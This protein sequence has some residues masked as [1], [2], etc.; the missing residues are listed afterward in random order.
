[1]SAPATASPPGAAPPTRTKIG[2]WTL[3]AERNELARDGQSVRL[4]PKVIEVLA[5]LAQRP[6]RVVPREELLSAVW[7]GVVVGD[8]TLT[9]AIIKLRKALGDDAHRPRYIETISK[10]GYRLIAPVEESSPETAGGTKTRM[11]RRGAG[12]VILGLALVAAAL[13]VGKSVRMPWPLATDT[14]GV[15]QP[16]IPLI[17]VLPFTNLSGDAKR[18]YFSDGIT[19]DIITGLGRFSG[20]RVMSLNAVEEFKGKPATLSALQSQLGARYIVKGS[21][22][23]ADRSV[24]VVLELSDAEKGVV[25]WSERIDGEG[26]QIF[27]IQDR[28]VRNLVGA[29]HVQLTQIEQQRVFSRPTES[30]EAYDLVL[31]ARSL[32]GQLDRR[33]NREARALLAKAEALSPNYGEVLTALGEAETQRALYGWVESPT[34]S[35]R[36]AEELA[37]R[38]LATS[39]T[40]T[41]V[42]AHVLLSSIYSNL[43]R[44]EESLQ[45][46]D[47]AL[48]LNPSDAAALWRRAGCLL[49]TGKV[50][51]A[52]AA[53]ETA[54]RFQP[55]MGGNA[56]NFAYAYYIAGRYA[57]ALALAETMITRYPENVTLNAIRAASLA[58]LGRDTEAR[59]AADQ[60]RRISPAFQVNNFA[61]RFVEAKHLAKIHEGLIK[62]GLE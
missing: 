61:L 19:E 37:R 17:A 10:R 53:H 9:Q 42:R 11:P 20:V 27:E 14:R 18:D 48:A 51:E 58:Q 23:E 56:S 8:D 57:D 22:R 46:A 2:D 28:I 25:L 35:M 34:D 55:G 49:F 40:R 45:H 43:G 16:S 7:P 21:V 12:A 24:R 30:L 29:L 6:G 60:V 38:T 62:A 13:V 33:A 3:D 50:D 52:I 1:M 39:D 32:L 44:F 41:H 47:L 36:R 54:R 4:E 15:A 5:F 59:R 31:R 26:A